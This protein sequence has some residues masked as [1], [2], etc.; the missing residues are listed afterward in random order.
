MKT[1]HRV[2]YNHVARH[3]WSADSTLFC[4]FVK[5]RY[6]RAGMTYD[7]REVTCGRCMAATPVVDLG[8]ELESYF[9][10]G[11]AGNWLAGWWRKP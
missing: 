4:G 8:E 6:Q 7:E 9:A 5:R 2:K 10:S 1:V 11:K 3:W